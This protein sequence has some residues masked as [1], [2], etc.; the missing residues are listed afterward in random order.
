M[1]DGLLKFSSLHEK[2]PHLTQD[3][4]TVRFTGWTELESYIKGLLLLWTKIGIVI[5]FG[6]DSIL[7]FIYKL[8]IL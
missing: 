6:F 8:N 5:G 1:M 7:F 2:S 3:L 4:V